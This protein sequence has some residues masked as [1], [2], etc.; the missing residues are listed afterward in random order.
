MMGAKAQVVEPTVN[1]QLLA[2]NCKQQNYNPVYLTADEDFSVAAI[3]S[4]PSFEGAIG[5]Q[6][7]FPSTQEFPQTQEYFNAMHQY[8]PQY[9]PGGS[10]ADQNIGMISPA[11]WA[12][13]YVLGEGLQNA[14]VP[15]GQ[16]VTT[17]D[18]KRG[19]SMIPQ[20]STNNGYTP[21]VYY[22]NGTTPEKPVTCFWT[23]KI[24][25][26]TYQLIGSLNSVSSQCEP[27]SL[28]HL[29]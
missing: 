17:A 22:G 24:V 26:D 14:N 4:T 19:L 28:L 16:T 7:A 8:A 25:G 20:G 29:K 11:S 21:P 5:F 12:G 1:N 10:D 23:T 15:A 9:L 27:A 3:K 13:A 6:D 18:V 2:A